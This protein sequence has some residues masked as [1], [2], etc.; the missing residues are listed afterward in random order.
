MPQLPTTPGTFDELQAK[1]GDI[2]T[3]IGKVPFDQIGQDARRRW[4]R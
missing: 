2:V 3:K 4:C 1:L